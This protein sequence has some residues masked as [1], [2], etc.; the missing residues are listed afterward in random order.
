MAPYRPSGPA[1]LPLGTL[2]ENFQAA[3]SA[4][5]W[6]PRSLDRRHSCRKGRGGED[7]TEPPPPFQ[8]RPQAAQPGALSSLLKMAR[9]VPT[10]PLAKAAGPGTQGPL[11]ASAKDEAICAL[12][13]FHSWGYLSFQH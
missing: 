13:L 10:K 6:G 8:H 11:P 3:C 7:R 4:S 9:V 1:P 2:L 5:G 12:E